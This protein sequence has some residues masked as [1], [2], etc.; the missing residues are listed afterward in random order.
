MAKEIFQ[1]HKVE[2]VFMQE[3]KTVKQTVANLRETVDSDK[4]VTLGAMFEELSPV[5]V[6]LQSVVTVKRV[7]HVAN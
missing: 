4:M 5:G 6:S 1:Q 2:V 7:A 3:G